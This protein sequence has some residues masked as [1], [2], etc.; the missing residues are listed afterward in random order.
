MVSLTTIPGKATEQILLKIVCKH[1]TGKPMMGCSQ[2][3]FMTEKLHLTSLT[4]F[5]DETGR[6]VKGKQTNLFIVG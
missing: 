2:H 3:R 5:Y 6:V 1:M 4:S